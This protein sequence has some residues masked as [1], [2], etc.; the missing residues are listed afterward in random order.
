MQPCFH[1]AFHVQK[2]LRHA[3]RTKRA[4]RFR[5]RRHVAIS[6]EFHCDRALQMRRLTNRIVKQATQYVHAAGESR[7]HAR[8]VVRL[9]LS[10]KRTVA[11]AR[12][13]HNAAPASR[14]SARERDSPPNAELKRFINV[15][16]RDSFVGDATAQYIKRLRNCIRAREQIPIIF[17]SAAVQK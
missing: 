8:R 16:P 15:K 12:H 5:S 14:A 6:V 7:V 10:C 17:P 9:S 1:T 3:I 11:L 4:Y 2:K 13:A